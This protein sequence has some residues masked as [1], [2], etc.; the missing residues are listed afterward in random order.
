LRQ[1]IEVYLSRVLITGG[2]GFIGSNLASSLIRQ[3][4]EVTVL[5]NLSRAG[6]A[7][8]LGCLRARHGKDSFR[9]IAAGVNDF[10]PVL[11]AAERIERVYHLAGQVTVTGSVADPLQDFS[12]NAL[13]TIHV[14]EA[15]RRTGDNPIFV[16]SSTNK[17]YGSLENI[18]FEEEPTRYRYRDL[19]LGI[20]ET[21]P[22][23][24][25]SPYG[26]SK[27]SGDQ[28]TRDYFR[29]FGLRTIVFRQSCVY[30]PGQ[31]GLEGQ[32]WL[33]WLMMASLWGWPITI[34]GNGKQVRDIL[35]VDDL[36][37]A[38][39]AAVN[40]IDKVAGQ[41]FNLGGG[42]GN[43]ISV[44]A[45]Y[46]PMIESLVGNRVEASFAGWRPGDQRIY[47]SDIQKAGQ[48]LGWKPRIS[49]NEGVGKQFEWV[50]G[51]ESLIHQAL[52]EVRPNL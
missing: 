15:S 38:Y 19:P 9:F 26:C 32:G 45:E 24:F 7:S 11:R 14:L 30:G 44:W 31:F 6:S 49:V 43:T 50:K 35:H 51:H 41:V 21:H 1:R 3:G 12:D 33:S 4:H 5:D 28:Y 39:D 48:L 29:I 37:E 47:V 2:A 46:G 34:C 40:G 13:G 18:D 16:Y 23:D 36:L 20:P 27:G 22:V 25:H 52:A 10:E 17:V 8:N 42:P